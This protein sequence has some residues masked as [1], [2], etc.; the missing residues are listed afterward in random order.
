MLFLLFRLS[1]KLRGIK[2]L[3]KSAPIHRIIV[4]LRKQF[5]FNIE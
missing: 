1:L 3:S 4:S 2:E 5:K